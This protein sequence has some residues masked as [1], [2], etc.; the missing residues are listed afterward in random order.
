VDR[1]IILKSTLR[2]RERVSENNSNDI[3]LEVSYEYSK[4]I[5]GHKK[6]RIS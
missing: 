5:S 1:I 3:A 2:N 4:E 6:G